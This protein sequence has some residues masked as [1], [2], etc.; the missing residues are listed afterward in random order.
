MIPQHVW[1]VFGMVVNSKTV[2]TTWVVMAVV[3]ALF[4]IAAHRPSVESPPTIQ[5][6]LEFVFD[7]V[8]GF[9]NDAGENGRRLFELLV[10]LVMFLGV[11]NV[12]GLLPGWGLIEGPN[13]PTADPNAAFALTLIVFF[14]IHFYGFRFRGLWGHIRTFFKP[15]PLLFPI[16]ALESLTNPLTLAMRLFG[17]IFAGELLIDVFLNLFKFGSLGYFISIPVQVFWLFFGAFVALI[18]AFI[19]MMLTMAYVSNSMSLEGH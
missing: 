10:T 19:F 4:L 16:N 1:L 18:Q 11:A 6:M 17:N 9:L 13:S 2:M 8:N 3:L 14:L 12:L 7:F 5:N 15:Y